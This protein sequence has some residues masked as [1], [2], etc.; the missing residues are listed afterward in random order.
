M[1]VVCNALH[2]QSLTTYSSVE[3]NNETTKNKSKT[4][5]N[6]KTT[7]TITKTKTKQMHLRGLRR[8][9]NCILH[10]KTWQIKNKE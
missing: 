6:P 7:T 9:V 8:P 2:V 10:S 4:K 5:Q 1:E 3:V